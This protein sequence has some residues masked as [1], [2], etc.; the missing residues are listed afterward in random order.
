MLFS[1]IRDT[2]T[3]K[4]KMLAGEMYNAMDPQLV[5]ERED[6]RLLFYQF[7]QLDESH[8][9]DRRKVLAQLMGSHGENLI[10]EPPFFCDY[11]SNI[12]LG[13]HVFMNYNCILL[14][15]CE[16]RIGS[17]TM[18][19]P[20]VQLYTATHPLEWKERASGLEFGKPITIGEHVWMGGGAIVCP[21]V[22][23]GDR[24]VIGAGSV[25]TKDIPSDVFAAGNPAKVVRE[26]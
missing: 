7:N 12:Y 20:N 19:G 16:I 10:I 26:I 3:E 15:V 6:C 22:S 24:S 21:G 17:H 23:I 5:K 1:V 25:V 4:E 2:M 14:D 18:F 9:Q 13:D 8:L 11:G